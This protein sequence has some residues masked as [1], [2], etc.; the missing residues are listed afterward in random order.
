MQR[1]WKS[2]PYWLAPHA[3]PSLFLYYPC[4]AAQ[5]TMFMYPWHTVI[6][7]LLHQSAV[8]KMHH[9]LAHRPV[10]WGHLV[11]WSPL[12]QN[13]YS[14]GQI[15]IKTKQQYTLLL[16]IYLN[17]N[18]LISPI[19]RHRMAEWVK[20]QPF[21][22]VSTR[23]LSSKIGA[24]LKCVLQSGK[25]TSKEKLITKDKKDTSLYSGNNELRT[26][27]NHKHMCTN[28]QCTQFHKAYY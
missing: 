3:F 23:S 28:Y 14:L 17:I 19:K 2:A 4:P 21:L 8:K 5:W 9:R 6:L 10:S 15:D 26:C 13:D 1:P 25:Y 16:I 12:F 11:N 7:A 18:D 24:T 20:K 27:Y 22:S